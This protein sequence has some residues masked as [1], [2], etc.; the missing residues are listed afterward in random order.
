MV[1]CQETA[2]PPRHQPLAIVQVG[3]EPPNPE[4]VDA[5]SRKLEA[6]AE[7]PSSF[8]QM[9]AT[10]GAFTSLSSI[11]P[12]VIAARSMNDCPRTALRNPLFSLRS[13]PNVR[14]PP[15]SIPPVRPH[16][17]ERGHTQAIP[18]DC[19]IVLPTHRLGHM[20][21]GAEPLRRP[22][23]RSASPSLGSPMALRSAP[24]GSFWFRWAIGVSMGFSRIGPR[25]PVYW[26][27]LEPSR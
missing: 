11:S 6:R 27:V 18:R 1:R 24:L 26:P 5:G 21:A 19:A 15:R 14:P 20:V 17:S 13:A 9:S 4:G 12:E 23:E 3:R 2:V 25:P 8:R 22:L 16:P 7:I 10:I